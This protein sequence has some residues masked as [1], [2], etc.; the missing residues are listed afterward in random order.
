VPLSDIAVRRAKPRERPYKLTDERGM[1][2]LVSPTGAKLWR[3][4]YRFAGKE[5]TL[6][7]GAY[8]EVTLAEARTARDD[9]RK[10]LRDGVDPSAVKRQKKLDQRIRAENTFE[11]VAKEW[12]AKRLAGWTADH[13]ERVLS[14][15]KA[16]VFPALGTRPIAEIRPPELLDVLRVVEKR[17]ALEV[18][19][20][21]K[22][23]CR[24]VFRYAIAT[25]RAESDPT[26]DLDGALKTPKREN[27]AALDASELPAYLGKLAAYDGHPQTRLA[28][29]LLAYTFVRTTE[30]RAAEW[31]E[32][33][34]GAAEWRIPAARMKMRDEHIVPLSRQSL[35]VLAELRA[36]NGHRRYVFMNLVDHE[37]FMSENTM[38]YAI[39]RMG[40]HSRATGHGFRATASTILNEQGF[41]SD[42]IE[43]QLAHAERNKVRAAYN[44]AQYLPER[45]KMMQHWADYLDALESGADVVPL[46][47]AA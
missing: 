23:R 4:K 44:R 25:G 1:Y 42:V 11:T 33:D 16:D 3:L 13:A 37:K 41:K 10:L 7:L 24:A 20:R 32:F 27:Y 14:S 19:S 30:L 35:A 2:L 31:S 28:L 40:Y 34:E 22:Q 18:A 8:D 38:L 45:R 36:L 12:H 6:A 47:K 39:Y 21:L 26:R 43:R 46:H 9:A 5:K 29:R 17:G 15:L